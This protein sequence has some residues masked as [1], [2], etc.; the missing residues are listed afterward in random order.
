MEVFVF[1]LRDDQQPAVC[2]VAAARRQF[3][4]GEV[5]DGQIVLR[6]FTRVE[7]VAWPDRHECI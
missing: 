7:P 1:P 2:M 3:G 5:G 4:W 6:F